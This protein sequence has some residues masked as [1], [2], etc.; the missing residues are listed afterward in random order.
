MLQERC[1]VLQKCCGTRKRLPSTA[2]VDWC[3]LADDCDGPCT[4]E[5]EQHIHIAAPISLLGSP[6]A[7]SH[8]SAWPSILRHISEQVMSKARLIN[9]VRSKSSGTCTRL[10]QDWTFQ[11]SNCKTFRSVVFGKYD[12]ASVQCV[13]VLHC[14]VICWPLTA[15]SW[16]TCTQ[17]IRYC[18]A[19]QSWK[20]TRA[21]NP[22]DVSLA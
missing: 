2:W 7:L 3:C 21:L 8:L 9:F 16:H 11:T 1:P 18:K 5:Q 15:A 12:S 6:S 17:D 22:I 4:D 14:F 20:I 19:W 13:P 10:K